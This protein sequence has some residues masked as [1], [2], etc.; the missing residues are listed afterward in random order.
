MHPESSPPHSIP[1]LLR[2]LRN[3][4]TTQLRQEVALAKTELH[5][6]SSINPHTTITAG[7]VLKQTRSAKTSTSLDAGWITRWTNSVIGCSRST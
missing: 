5:H 1:G 6:S 3:E 7:R 4:T 2:E